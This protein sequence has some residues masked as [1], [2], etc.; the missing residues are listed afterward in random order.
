MFDTLD[1]I[2]RQ[3]EVLEDARAEFKEVLLRD[4]GVRSPNTEEMAGEMVA[5]AN[6]EGGVIFLGVDDD[7]VVRGIPA[8][9]TGD[10]EA[11]VINVAS[12]NCDPPIRPILR[13]EHLHDPSGSQRLVILVEI[14]G[15]STSTARAEGVTTFV[16][17]RPS[18]S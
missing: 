8:E 4:R 9:H 10:V 5:F 11:W 3:L 2:R 7:G 1:E 16:S 6:A 12:N 14:R 15:G 17:A 13:K 18:S